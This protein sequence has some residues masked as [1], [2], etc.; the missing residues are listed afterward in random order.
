MNQT[1]CVYSSSSCA[2]DQVYFQLAAEL[3]N[4]I[5]KREDRFLF[6]GGMI[7]LMGAVAKA[8]HESKGQVIGVIPRA[9]NLPGIVYKYCD[10]LIVTEGLRER[11]AMMDARSDAFIALP[12]G[13]G[14]LEEILEII[15]LKQ[16]KYHNKP[17]VI[18]NA[19]NFYDKLL[20]QFAVIIGQDF[21]KPESRDLFFVAGTVSEAL[22]YIDSYTP[23]PFDDKWFTNVENR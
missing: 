21:A 7:G 18:L 19:N 9:L 16:L 1:I 10:E 4:A 23:Y 5:A 2:I 8:V 17:V 13:F 12:G 6:G 15:A 11:K 3:G 14:T 22:E 20:E